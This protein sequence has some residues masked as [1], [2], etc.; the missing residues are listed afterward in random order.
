MGCHFLLQGIF[1]T[2]GLNQGVQ[3]CRQIFYPLSHQGSHYTPIKKLIL[4]KGKE[5]KSYFSTQPFKRLPTLLTDLSDPLSDL[6]SSFS[7]HWPLDALQTFL[8]Y[9]QLWGIFHFLN[10]SSSSC[11]TAGCLSFFRFLVKY[12]LLSWAF[13]DHSPNITISLTLSN[14]HFR[15]IFLLITFI[16][17]YVYFVCPLPLL[18][19]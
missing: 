6:M 13:P 3:Y 15:I 19:K 5:A 1:P 4:K 11:C 17:L 18:L 7:S 9:S 2:E 16:I 12:H 14:L 8:T 10:C